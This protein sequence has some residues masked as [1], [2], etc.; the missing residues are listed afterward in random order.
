MIYTKAIRQVLSRYKVKNVV[1]GIAHI[2]G[3]GLEENIHRI[4]PEGFEIDI[5][6]TAW[7]RPPVFGW[8]QELGQVETE[9]MFRVF[10]MGL[11]LTLIVSPYYADAIQRTLSQH[12]HENWIIG[13]VKAGEK[14]VTVHNK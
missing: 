11:G 6:G 1:H 2:T 5:D 9:E 13:S 7:T 14:R 10:N 8:L 3:G 4:T 12:G